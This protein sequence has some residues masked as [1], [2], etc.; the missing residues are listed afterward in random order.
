VSVP[1]RRGPRA[2][3][4]LAYADTN[5]FVSLLVGPGH[6]LHGPALGVF[7]RVADGRLGLIVTPIVV[8]ELVYVT[9]SLLGWTHQLIAQR[10]SALLTADGIAL[11]EGP[12]LL[13]ALRLFGDVRKLDFADAYLAA[14]AIEVGPPAIVSFDADLDAVGGVLRISV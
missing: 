2:R 5:I 11:V 9:R 6:P 1:S 12:T 3:P 4:D 7:R 8:A 13:R 10:L 14:I